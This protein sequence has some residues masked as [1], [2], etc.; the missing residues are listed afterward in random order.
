METEAANW[1]ASD[2][3]PAIALIAHDRPQGGHVAGGAGVSRPAG[4]L[5]PLDRDPP[6]GTLLIE[7]LG[8][9]VERM[10]S[11]PM[12]G[13]QQDRRARGGRQDRAGHFS[14]DR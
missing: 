5:P 4:A 12:G 11:G 7:R 8:L 3:A 14:R 9:A 1:S 2:E 6:S 10:L 13:D